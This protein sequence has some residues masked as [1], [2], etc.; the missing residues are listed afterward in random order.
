MSFAGTSAGFHLQS[1][2]NLGAFRPTTSPRGRVVF[3]AIKARTKAT[4][5]N[6][7]IFYGLRGIPKKGAN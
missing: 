5:V 1:T 3:S 7:E 2:L 4:L 6:I